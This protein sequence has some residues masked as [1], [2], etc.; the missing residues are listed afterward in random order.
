MSKYMAVATRRLAA[1]AHA[2]GA[3]AVRMRFC[4]RR[5][6]GCL[7]LVVIKG[8]ALTAVLRGASRHVHVGGM[9]GGW[10]ESLLLEIVGTGLVEELREGG[11][12]LASA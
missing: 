5:H 10:R 8:G 2:A 9:E 11:E 1:V 3:R 7:L 12:G 4:G 6:G